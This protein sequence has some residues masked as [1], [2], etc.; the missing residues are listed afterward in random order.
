MVVSTHRSGEIAMLEPLTVN[1]LS[2]QPVT[3]GENY[4]YLGTDENII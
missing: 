4:G 1:N 2:I 3:T